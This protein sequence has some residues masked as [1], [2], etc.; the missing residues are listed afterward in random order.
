M[1]SSLSFN[2]ILIAAV[3]L[4][5]ASAF[6]ANKGSLD[7]QHPASV[8]GKQLATGT[9]T[10]RWEGTG[11][12]V[13]L[14]I[15]QGKNVVISAP[16][17]VVKIQGKSANNSA[18]LQNNPDGSSTVSEIRFGGKDFAL[19]LSSDASGAGSASGAAR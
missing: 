16:A 10:V 15:Y 18:V 6:A 1:K 12:Q 14:K 13:D 8:A 19:Q 17:R 11:D 3:V 4:L 7:L 9:Y 2:G 5:A